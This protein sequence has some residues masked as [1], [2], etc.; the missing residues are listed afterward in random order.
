METIIKRT[1]FKGFGLQKDGNGFYFCTEINYIKHAA[2]VLYDLKSKKLYKRIELSKDLFYGNVLCVIISNLKITE[3]GYLLSADGKEFKDRFCRMLDNEKKLCRF[4]FPIEDKKF[5]ADE[6]PGIPFDETYFYLANI[7]GYTMLSKNIVNPGTFKAFEKKLL[8]IK[9]LGVT[10]IIFM[11]V[12]EVC[13]PENIVYDYRKTP[14]NKKSNYWGFGE[15]FHYALKN[16][17]GV[18]RADAEFKKMVIKMHSLGLE[19]ILMMEFRDS[20][21]EY[22]LDVLKFYVSEYHIDGF[23][24]IGDNLPIEAVCKDPFLTNTKILTNYRNAKDFSFSYS[25][26]K[27]NLCIIDEQFMNQ[28]RRFAKGDEDLVSYISFS[29]RENS[30]YYSLVHFP[31]DF[32]GFS[33][34]DLVSYNLK[35]NEANDEENHDGTD[36]NYSWNCGEEGPSKK[37]TVMSLRKRMVRNL[38]ISSFLTQGIP[39][40]V[41]GDENLNSQNGNNNPYCQDNEI[42][43]TNFR[44]DKTATDFY[45][46]TQNLLAFRKRHSILHQPKELMLFDYMSCKV[47]D[48]SFHGAE[49]FRMDQ[50]PVSR[51]FGVLYYGDYSKQYTGKKEESVFVVYN[52]N[53]EKRDFALPLFGKGYKWKLL[54]STDGSTDETFDEEKAKEYKE[55]VYHA[56]GRTISVFLLS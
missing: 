23:R 45:K 7:K 10:S 54:Y 32:S 25:P 49:A 24:L 18:E 48:I 30:K 15:G 56:E 40:I 26:S 17:L 13:E 38:Y 52:M 34:N 22:I 27:K 51:E 1:S 53:W 5:K 36:Y 44:K 6:F 41:A 19:C 28:V 11:P 47:P 46:F 12:Y 2:I 35:H 4:L 50:N 39:M 43:W 31:T 37:K 16:E 21:K 55:S 3:F 42:G 9:A 33:L 20:N 8:S 29:I 14:G